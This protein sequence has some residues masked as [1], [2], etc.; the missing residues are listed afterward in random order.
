MSLDPGVEAALQTAAEWVW[1]RY[2][3]DLDDLLE[4]AE[5][6]LLYDDQTGFTNPLYD[7]ALVVFLSHLATAD[8]L[9]QAA[10]LRQQ[11]TGSWTK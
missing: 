1:E 11:R 7:Q 2:D 6:D 5:L 8:T 9:R 4:Q 3:V 10:N